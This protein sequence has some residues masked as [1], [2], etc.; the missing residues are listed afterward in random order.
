MFITFIER[1]VER[2]IAPVSREEIVNELRAWRVAT[3]P[4]PSRDLLG[5]R[6]LWPHDQAARHERAKKLGRAF[7]HRGGQK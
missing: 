5:R 6:M 3:D 7:A 1:L 4:F 2:S